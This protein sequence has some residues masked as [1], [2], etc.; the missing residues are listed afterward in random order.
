MRSL[1]IL[2][3]FVVAVAFV[4]NDLFNVLM[5]LKIYLMS[6]LVSV[7]NLSLFDL[8]SDLIHFF[9]MLPTQ[10]E[11]PRSRWVVIRTLG[12]RHS[13]AAVMKTP[14]NARYC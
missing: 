10:W 11:P 13:G 14:C 7:R 9:D 3:C 2:L 12:D 4:G 5:F 6:I 8:I 1:L